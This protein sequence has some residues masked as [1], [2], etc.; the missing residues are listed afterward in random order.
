MQG[1]R[2]LDEMFCLEEERV[3]SQD[4]VVRYQGQ[5]LQVEQHHRGPAAPGARI[6]VREWEDGRL[7][8]RY[9]GSKMAWAEDR[10]LAGSGQACAGT[11]PAPTQGAT[12]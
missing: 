11:F 3:L 9:R 12:R 7:E 6:V 5:L 2:Q 4:W 10:R 8:V 1:K